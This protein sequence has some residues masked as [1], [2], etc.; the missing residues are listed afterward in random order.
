M[1]I[2]VDGNFFYLG[3]VARFLCLPRKHPSAAALRK[4]DVDAF[5]DGWDMCDETSATRSPTR[6]EAFQR[7]MATTDHITICWVDDDNNEIET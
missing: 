7:E 5:N 6:Y 4:S 3:W 1:N 2:S